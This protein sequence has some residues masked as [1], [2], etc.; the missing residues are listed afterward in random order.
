MLKR[1]NIDHTFVISDTHFFHK[2][3]LKYDRIGQA[4]FTDS[5]QRFELMKTW[6]NETVGETDS[7]ILL[8]DTCF[9]K[10]EFPRL[11]ELNGIK[12]LVRGN[13]DEFS[14]WRFIETAGFKQIMPRVVVAGLLFTHYPVHPIEIGRY[15]GNVH[16]HLHSIV[17]DDPHYLNVCAENI[18]YRPKKLREILDHFGLTEMYLDSAFV[19]TE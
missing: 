4:Y 11:M 3:I 8:G 2:N 14:E 5:E 12:Y 1:W 16:G 19:E 13:H 6:W 18:N 15:R 17:I 7:V 10:T 9:K